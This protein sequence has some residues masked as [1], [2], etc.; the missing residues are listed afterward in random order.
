MAKRKH[1]NPRVKVY[2][3]HRGHYF[4]L[5]EAINFGSKSTPEL[6]IKGLAETYM[7]IKDDQKRFDGNIH[8]GQ[9]IR[10][11]DGRHQEFTYHKDGS[12]LSEVVQPSGEKEYYN[13]YGTG[14]RWTPLA[15]I[16]T[17]QPV[18]IM[19]LMS[20]AQYRQTFIEKKHGLI[21]Y[22]VK[23]DRLFEFTKGQGMLV[24]VYLKHKDYPLAKYCFDDKIYSDVLMKLGEDLELCVFIQ[25]QMHPD[26][27][28]AML[29]NN[30]MF[31]DRLDGFEYLDSV[32]REHIFD[33]VFVD[34]WNIIQE[35]G[36][37]FD[38]SEKMMQ[39]IESVDPLYDALLAQKALIEVHKPTLVRR[40]LDTLDGKYEGYLRL[41]KEDRMK[42]VIALYA[43]MMTEMKGKEPCG[44]AQGTV[45]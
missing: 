11:V 4:R 38:V 14:E 45:N 41:P 42:R 18:M 30:Y 16:K 1:K 10:F 8:E 39:V 13:P 23:N 7:Q 44:E 2:F 28:G 24:L 31:V 5:L 27:V 35:G 34:F 40:L 36:R 21:N 43:E 32:L 15:E 22:E 20:M 33:R 37:Y 17:F 9:W 26:N 6:K 19:Q 25:K 12:I 3:R 29:K